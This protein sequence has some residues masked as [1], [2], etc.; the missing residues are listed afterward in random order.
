MK[1]RVAVLPGDGIGP[2][3]TTQSV[4]VLKTVCRTFR[5]E[6]Q[7][8][9]G[10]IAGS[11][12]RKYGT[13]YPKSTAALVDRADA[14]LFGNIGSF[15]GAKELHQ[16]PD[17]SILALRRQL[18]LSINIRPVSVYRGLEAFSP[19]KAE[20]LQKGMD[21]VF[22]RDIA[23]GILCSEEEQSSGEEGAE[24]SEREYY[25]ETIIRNTVH[26]AF[27]LASERR[28][29]LNFLDKSNVLGTSQLWKR[30]V[31]E[32]NVFFPRVSVRH[33]YIDT[34]AMRLIEDPSAF[35]VVVT[36]NLFGDIISDEGTAL[37]GT[38]FL[39]PSVELSRA[40]KVIYTPN[41]LHFTDESIAGQNLVNPIGAIAC[42]PL[43][44]KM[45]FGL[46]READAAERAIRGTILE[47]CATKDI[48]VSP[49]QKLLSTEEMGDRIADKISE[50]S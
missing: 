47:G 34:A 33:Y 11:A 19:L 13:P 17:Y 26:E 48:F 36:S 10:E 2:E 22:V 25:N 5:H 29:I 46:Q 1:L 18:Q 21:V 37:T 30:I 15:S 41:Q 44:L 42:I 20:R 24:I 43:L 7:V 3:I 40:G 32:E 16:K 14:V 31:E 45:S 6:L 38:P 8:E 23:G 50:D 35:D 9:Y 4:K 39:Y 28:G 12:I 27:I 49:F